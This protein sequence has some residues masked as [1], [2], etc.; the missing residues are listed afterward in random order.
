MAV[1]QSEFC[2]YIHDRNSRRVDLYLSALFADMSRSYVQR[3][4]V[5]GS[6]AVNTVPTH[7]NH[8]VAKGDIITITWKVDGSKFAAEPMNIEVIYDSPGFAVIN[9]DPGINV[10]PVPG[11]GGKSGTLVN[12][13]LHHF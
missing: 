4:I 13:L 6:V 9:K 8:K 3:L 10:H 1:R 7:K 2:V 12:G 5:E 11:E